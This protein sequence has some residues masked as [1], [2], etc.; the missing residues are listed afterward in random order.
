[1]RKNP[2]FVCFL[3]F[4]VFSVT[5]GLTVNLKLRPKTRPSAVSD[6]RLISTAN[7]NLKSSMSLQKAETAV[8][9]TLRVLA[10]RAEFVEDNDRE[11]TGNGKFD[12]SNESSYFLNAPPHNRTY[13]QNQLLAMTNY[14]KTVS[15]GKLILIGEVFPEAEDVAYQLP[16]QMRY[17]SPDTT[18][19]VLDQRLAELLQDALKAA[20][21]NDNIDFS[22]YDAFIIFH[23]GVGAEYAFDLDTTPHDVPS[24]FLNFQDLKRTIGKDDPGFD[25]IEVTNLRVRDGII[26]PETQNQMGYDIGLL[27]TAVLMFGHQIGLPNLYN[28]D[29]GRPG[30][31]VFGIMDQGSSN[32]SGLL[33]SQPSAWSKIFLGWETP[34]MVTNGTH[35]VAAA[36]AEN[37]NKIY[38]IPINASEYFLV[39]NRQRYILTDRNTTVGYDAQGLRIEFKED[40]NLSTPGGEESID[41]I[42]QVDEY[43]F[44]LPG[45]GILIWHIDEN[46]ILQYYNENRVNTNMDH[47][48]V[49]LEEADGAQDIGHFFNFFGFTGYE[50]GSEWDM[51]WN[52]NEGYTYANET[53]DV[54][55]TP[56][57]MPDT[58]AYSGANSHVYITRFSDIDSIMSFTVSLETYQAGFPQKTGADNEQL[59]MHTG[60][61]DGD[62][63]L[64]IVATAS[65]G[66]IFAWNHDG[67]KV[68]ANSDS[69]TVTNVNTRTEKYPLAIYAEM[70]A[71]T[72]HSAALADFDNDGDLDVVAATNS[73]IVYV[74]SEND[75][76]GNGRADI[77]LHIDV[78][79]PIATSPMIFQID[80]KNVIAVGLENGDVA[81]IR[82]TGNLLWKKNVSAAQIGGLATSDQKVIAT[83][84][85]G[86][87]ALLD[88]AG[89]ISWR[90][91]VGS[92]LKLNYPVA[93]DINKDGALEILVT[94]E[95][96]TISGFDFNGNPMAGFTNISVDDKLSSPVL[97]DL[98]NNGFM[99]LITC[100]DG[101]LY[102]FNYNGSLLD[103]FPIEITREKSGSA[104][105]EPVVADLDDDGYAEI[106]VSGATGQIIAY[107]YD[108]GKVG[109][110]PLSVAKG[111]TSVPMLAD[112]TNDGTTNLAAFGDDGNMYVWKLNYDFNADNIFWAGFRNDVQHSSFAQ[113]SQGS[114][115]AENE[116][117]PSKT[118]YNYPNPT[119]GNTTTIRYWLNA[120]A[121]VTIRIYDMAGEFVKEIKSAGFA[122]TANEYHLNVSE[123]QSGVYLTRVE[124]SNTQNTSVSFFKMAVVK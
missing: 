33:P 65:N 16:Q 108:S 21:D 71:E 75:D 78:Q 74:F 112:I 36:L 72:D 64:E 109:G 90:T 15:N 35:D 116:L 37:P 93:G 82:N 27:G 89:N 47:R 50:A 48:G 105:P 4:Y 84:Y 69:L 115:P 3:L 19:E 46:V 62:P 52:Q 45:S 68:I 79:T 40:G 39:E 66:K 120:D 103:N 8:P 7:Y 20:D 96:G 106:M 111:I 100:G 98:N 95:N 57:S 28:S 55:F 29:N 77:L 42:V 114:A 2:F 54:T 11:T 97:A 56:N 102:A 80:G 44:G 81:V 5:N 124:A 31:G 117:M 6:R 60:N 101:R 63:E 107:K 26:L 122:R 53:E 30:I 13:F 118:V 23:P 9:D 58:R 92:G 32:F 99:E 61:L 83:S 85:A 22:Q 121:D 104:Y 88:G 91:T 73:G 94:T 49:D 110:F 51:W 14:F 119:E 87:I 25:G 12:L 76:D 17:Y 1:M 38:K 43:D 34:I 24:V 41:V 59:A 70:D 113:T 18:E 86:D 10:I 67:S 123:F